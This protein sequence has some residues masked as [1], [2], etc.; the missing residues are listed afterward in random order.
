MGFHRKLSRLRGASLR[1]SLS[2]SLSFS[3]IPQA[4]IETS[5]NKFVFSLRSPQVR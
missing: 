2:L 5:D 3:E 1:L 4:V